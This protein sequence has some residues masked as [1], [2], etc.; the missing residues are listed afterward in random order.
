M[1]NIFPYLILILSSV[2]SAAQAGVSKL[3]SK[4]YGNS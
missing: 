1:N 4:K 3:Y 2:L